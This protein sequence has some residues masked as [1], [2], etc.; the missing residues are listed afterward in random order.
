MEKENV[1]ALKTSFV[2]YPGFEIT[3]L[4]ELYS[5]LSKDSILYTE[6][7]RGGLG[8][9]FYDFCLEILT[10][11]SLKDAIIGG[12]VGNLATDILKKT[13]SKITVSIK[14]VFISFQK[15]IARNDI[16]F[17]TIESIKIKFLSSEVEIIKIS[18]TLDAK[19][20]GLIWKELEQNYKFLSEY[21]SENINKIII[22]VLKDIID[23]KIVFT[24]PSIFGNG[25]TSTFTDEDYYKYWVIS[26]GIN[27]W[28]QYLFD[29]KNKKIIENWD[30]SAFRN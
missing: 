6:E 21:K 23:E 28:Q 2:S 26:Y 11:I 5:D 16:H 27:T 25:S 24:K 1:I 14:N 10:G 15:F 8:G 9:G 13:T 12:V 20:I 3:G 17:P 22:P 19:T 4:E 18:E 30:N 7:Y 29:V